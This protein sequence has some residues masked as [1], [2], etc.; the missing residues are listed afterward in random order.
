MQIIQVIK[1]QLFRSWVLRVIRIF[2]AHVL[3]KDRRSVQEHTNG[4]FLEAHMMILL[5]P[6]NFQISLNVESN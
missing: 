6:E 1:D 5:I 2:D 3:G 4:L